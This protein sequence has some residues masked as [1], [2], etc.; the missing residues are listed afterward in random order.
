MQTRDV[1]LG[2]QVSTRGTLDAVGGPQGGGVAAGG[3]AR[4]CDCR[5]GC[6]GCRRGVVAG[7]GDVA[8]WVEVFG[9]ED[10]VEGEG[11]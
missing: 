5:G 9:C 1:Q 10:E 4:V 7:E 2:D 8:W 3:V 11:C 6:V